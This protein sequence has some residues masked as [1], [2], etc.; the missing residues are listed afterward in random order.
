MSSP[1][2]P[3]VE[4]IT[5]NRHETAIYPAMAMLAGMQL[6]VFTPLKDGALTASEIAAA[7]DVKPAK[8]IPLLYALAAA[9]LLVVQT[10]RFSNTAEADAY[11]V[12]GRPS[13]MGDAKRAFYSDIWQAL[14]KTADTIRA[15]APQHKHD[16]YAMSE[17]EMASFFLGQH[18]HAVAAGEQLTKM[19]DLSAFRNLLEVGAGSGGLS[20]GIVRG[21]PQLRVIAS[22]LPQV[23]PVT[24]RF[25]EEAKLSDRIQTSALDVVAD[26]PKGVFDAAVM[27]NLIQV[28]S[29]ANAQAAVQNVATS[30]APGGTILIIG[31]MIEDNRL[32]PANLVGQNLV[33]LNVYDDGLFYTE[34]EYRALLVAAGFADIDIRR[35]ELSGGSVL[36]SAR[37][38]A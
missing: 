38:R 17:D 9:E 21:L 14:L 11:L 26:A 30:L 35:G 3:T 22:D 6:D 31:A 36:I 10:G 27:R 24:R 5:I 29:L 34:G 13:Y 33:L 18:V 1:N 32:S 4:P 16:F 12:R 20:V 19:Q 28:L 8:L 7:I 15:G 23:I 25:I 37:K 2:T